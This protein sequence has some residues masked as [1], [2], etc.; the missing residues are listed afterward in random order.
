MTK[1]YPIFWCGSFLYEKNGLLRRQPIK[2]DEP[3]ASTLSASH[4]T[5]R[6]LHLILPISESKSQSKDEIDTKELLDEMKNIKSLFLEVLGTCE[7][8]ECRV[9]LLEMKFKDCNDGLR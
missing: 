5:K 7:S 4:S 1:L 9:S 6:H 8:F 2:R 3:T